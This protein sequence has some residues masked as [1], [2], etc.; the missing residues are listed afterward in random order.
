MN[1]LAAQLFQASTLIKIVAAALMV[2]GLSVLAE[3]VS[4]RFAGLVS[5]YPLGAAISLFF[6]GMEIGPDF[7]GQGAVYMVFGLLGLHAYLLGYYLGVRLCGGRTGVWPTAAASVLGLGLYFPGVWLVQSVDVGLWG[8]VLSAAATIVVFTFFFRRLENIR[9]DRPV[10][11]NPAAV[12]FRAGFAALVVI[13]VT[14]SAALVGERWSGVLSAFPMTMFPLMVVLNLNYSAAHVLT[15]IKNVPRGLGCL[16]VY[17]LV[18]ALAYPRHG[19]VWGTL[20][21]YV[22]STAYLALVN[23]AAVRGKPVTA[24]GPAAK[25]T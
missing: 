22:F 9:I 2:V 7:A 13:M 25:G 1:E 23:R 21:G 6:I 18:V 14:C 11:L 8:A 5:G 4:P 10:R 19:V 15:L 24:P 12:A 17:G 20:E 16:V 3:K